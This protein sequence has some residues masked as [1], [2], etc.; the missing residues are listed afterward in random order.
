MFYDI[1]DKYSRLEQW[2]AID[3]NYVRRPTDESQV[4]SSVD[5]HTHTS[6]QFSF[7]ENITKNTNIN[8]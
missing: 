7:I 4:S 5:T 1:K 6:N 8:K 2:K 3:L